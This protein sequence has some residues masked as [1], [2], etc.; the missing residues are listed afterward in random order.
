MGTP[1]DKVGTARVVVAVRKYHRAAPSGGQPAARFPAPIFH[2]VLP[3]I[4]FYIFHSTLPHRITPSQN[5][6]LGRDSTCTIFAIFLQKTR[7]GRG[8]PGKNSLKIKIAS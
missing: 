2:F 1:V 8:S 4:G 3:I 6:N 7:V 5:L